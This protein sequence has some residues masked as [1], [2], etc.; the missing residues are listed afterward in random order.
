MRRD[1]EYTKLNIP[2]ININV[3]KY[4]QNVGRGWRRHTIGLFKFKE[5]VTR[6]I[7]EKVQYIINMGTDS[8][9]VEN[10]DLNDKIIIFER[11]RTQSKWAPDFYN[12]RYIYHTITPHIYQ[13]ASISKPIAKKLSE[14][15]PLS[16]LINREFYDPYAYYSHHYWN[17][18]MELLEIAY[19]L[20]KRYKPSFHEIVQAVQILIKKFI[21][22]IRRGLHRLTYMD[23]RFLLRTIVRTMRLTPFDGKSDDNAFFH[24]FNMKK[25]CVNNFFNSFK[26]SLKP[27]YCNISSV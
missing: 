7:S 10:S 21:K 25:I 1:M 3:P 24:L 22:N 18:I 20:N 15:F 17:K 11:I 13:P 16:E 12:E 14:K 4:Y 23:L 27:N 8:F 5:F 26:C 9:V 6:S 19:S 2:R